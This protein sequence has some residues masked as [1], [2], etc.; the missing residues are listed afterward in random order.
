MGASLVLMRASYLHCTKKVPSLRPHS[1]WAE[2][3]V[4]SSARMAYGPRW[5]I[6]C[7]DSGPGGRCHS[8][9]GT[10]SR[11]PRIKERE[12]SSPASL[13]HRTR[14]RSSRLTDPSFR[15]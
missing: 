10:G 12:R 2:V 9:V 4:R 7:Q 3:E 14:T 11:G 15:G 13:K 8:R 5:V 6:F 1:E